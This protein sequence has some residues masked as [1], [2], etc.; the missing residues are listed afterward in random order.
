MIGP[1]IKALVAM[2][3]PAAAKTLATAIKRTLNSNIYIEAGV[4]PAKEIY[5]FFQPAAETY[6]KMSHDEAKKILGVNSVNINEINE[7]FE[8]LHRLNTP[9]KGGSFYL[10]CKLLGAKETLLN[11]K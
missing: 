10:Q 1:L 3:G 8:R 2:Y 5:Q 9:D 6:R 11:K 4:D 7:K